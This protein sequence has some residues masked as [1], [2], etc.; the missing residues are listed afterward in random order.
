MQ[1]SDDYL[2]EVLPREPPPMNY[3]PVDVVQEID[4]LRETKELDGEGLLARSAFWTYAI[5]SELGLGNYRAELRRPP[6]PF[7]PWAFGHLGEARRLSVGLYDNKEEQPGFGLC[8]DIPQWDGPPFYMVDE[9][10][11]PRLGMHFPFAL[12][13]VSTELHALP[14]PTKGTAACW[15]RCNKT[16]QWGI[17]TAAHAVGS[18][19]GQP[20]PLDD[21]STGL[22]NL[23]YYQPIDAA[24][25][26]TPAPKSPPRHLAVNR[27]AS[28]GVPVVVETQGGPQSRT[29]VSVFDSFG[30]Y[31]TREF[32]VLLLLDQPCAQGD[33]G[34]LVRRHNGMACGIYTGAQGAPRR[35]G[36][37]GRALNFAQAMFALDTT[38][39][40]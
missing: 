7:Y 39:Y 37:T 1:Y 21:G 36:Q 22:S 19:P 20:V 25:V 8:V 4:A 32:A 24:F 3:V 23:A 26:S 16:G 11:F 5:F 18:T 9:I 10:E 29:V 30:T 6:Y 17:I 38:A 34:S 33:S 14:N 15:A 12:R 28:A 27:F 35:G 31:R 13:T 2:R 40:R